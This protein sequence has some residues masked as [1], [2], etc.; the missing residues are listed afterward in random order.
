MVNKIKLMDQ[1]KK[2][3]S[4]PNG[5]A[6]ARKIAQICDF[7]L[8]PQND[9]LINSAVRVVGIIAVRGE[10]ELLG[11]SYLQVVQ[12]G[13]ILEPYLDALRKAS[14]EEWLNFKTELQLASLPKTDGRVLLQLALI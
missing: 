8:D 3:A 12:E 2:V 11:R 5:E 14:P 9:Y 1:Y 7:S 4:F 10:E 6:V 13:K